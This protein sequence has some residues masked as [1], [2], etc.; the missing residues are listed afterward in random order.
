M[1]PRIAIKTD[2][3]PFDSHRKKVDPLGEQFVK[4]DSYID[5]E[6]LTAE[7]NRVGSRRPEGGSPRTAARHYA[8]AQIGDGGLPR[9]P[10]RSQVGSGSHLLW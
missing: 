10:G 9:D 4:I 2:L 7:A 5:F 6:A 3:F 1:K 8:G